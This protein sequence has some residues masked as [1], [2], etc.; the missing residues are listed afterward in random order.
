MGEWK[1]DV[2]ETVDGRDV[3][4]WIIPAKLGGEWTVKDGAQSFSVKLEQTFQELTGS[5]TIGGKPS[6]VTNGKINGDQVVF[7]LQIDGKPA[8][9]AGKVSGNKIDG[10]AGPTA[11]KRDWSASRSKG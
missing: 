10:M 5:A 6:P 3:Y 2:H 4:L 1:P 8:T 7:T 11:T 9:F